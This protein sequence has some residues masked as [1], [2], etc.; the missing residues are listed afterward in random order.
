MLSKLSLLYEEVSL[1]T[2]RKN[3]KVPYRKASE[4]QNQSRTEISLVGEAKL[5]QSG[6]FKLKNCF[7]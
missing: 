7:I 6:G 1:E 5:L 2:E 3:I 4:H